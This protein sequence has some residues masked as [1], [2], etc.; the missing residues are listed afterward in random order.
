M[1][2]LL[3]A[4]LCTAM[5]VGLLSCGVGAAAENADTDLESIVQAYAAA[6][7]EE[8][9]FAVSRTIAYDES[10]LTNAYGY[11]TAGSEAEH[12]TADWIAEEMAAIGL[13]E[14]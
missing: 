11:R 5:I 13:V 12:A 2:R 10:L 7:A 9:A 1:K 3:S 8:Y 6:N 4:L 14:I